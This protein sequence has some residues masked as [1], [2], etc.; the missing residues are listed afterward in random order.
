MEFLRNQYKM[1]QFCPLP[2]VDSHTHTCNDQALILASHMRNGKCITWS[3]VRK[4][5]TDFTVSI[6]QISSLWW[7]IHNYTETSSFCTTAMTYRS[8]KLNQTTQYDEILTTR[9]QI[10]VHDNQ[11]KHYRKHARTKERSSGKCKVWVL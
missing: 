1:R 9:I 11:S 8:L 3:K 4:T 2:N 5:A 10:F 7:Q 6:T